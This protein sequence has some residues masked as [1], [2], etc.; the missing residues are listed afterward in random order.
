MSSSDATQWLEAMN[1]ELDSIK[2]NDI[3]ELTDLPNGRKAIGCKWILTKKFKVDGSLEKYKA[4]LVAKGFTQQPGIDFVDTYSPVAKFASIRV[5]MAVVVRMDLELHQLDVKTTF[6]NGELKE[7]IYMMQPDGFQIQDNEDKVYKLKKSLYGLKQSSRQWYL[8]FHQAILE[9]GYVV[10]PLDHCVYIWKND[11]KLAIL[12][13][14]V[15]DILLA[16]NCPDMIIKT[17]VVFGR[18]L[19]L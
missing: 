10:S 11:D 1:E 4:R 17:K 2:K 8:K 16:G 7:K 6:L 14:Y 13:L 9:I 19:E 5:L 12:S 18:V 3:W 15:G